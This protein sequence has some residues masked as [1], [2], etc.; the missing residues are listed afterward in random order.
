[1]ITLTHILGASVAVHRQ[2]Q[3]VAPKFLFFS[4]APLLGAT[5]VRFPD[6]CFRTLAFPHNRS[7]RI[8]N[9]RISKML[10]CDT[11]MSERKNKKPKRAF[12]MIICPLMRFPR[13][14]DHMLHSIRGNSSP[15]LVRHRSYRNTHRNMS[16]GTDHPLPQASWFR[17][18]HAKFDLT[19]LDPAER[20]QR[21]CFLVRVVWSAQDLL[22]GGPWSLNNAES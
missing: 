12:R 3:L 2:C 7:M 17:I 22:R 16:I 19:D 5:C 11:T 10:F 18:Y 20:K 4:C 8:F 6:G 21:E 13:S 9:I 15:I 1:M 14:R